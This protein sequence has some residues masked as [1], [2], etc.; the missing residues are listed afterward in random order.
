MLTTA[1]LAFTPAPQQCQPA[2]RCASTPPMMMVPGLRWPVPGE[3]GEIV[4]AAARLP[5]PAVTVAGSARAASR[6][7]AARSEQTR[8][9]RRNPPITCSKRRR[10]NAR[11]RS[12]R[13]IAREACCSST[14]GPGTRPQP[15]VR[16]EITHRCED[17]CLLSRSAQTEPG[18]AQ[19]APKEGTRRSAAHALDLRLISRT[20]DI[21]MHTFVHRV[22]RAR[23]HT[24]LAPL[25][26]TSLSLRPVPR[27]RIK[28]PS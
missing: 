26:H 5:T 23:A 22:P 17:S 9:C 28:G 24:L 14:L 15:L 1:A 12:S 3:L 6:Q 13:A 19:R 7:L 21:H 11:V 20:R 2:C 27:S 18:L 8:R 16:I 4:G 10:P 25:S